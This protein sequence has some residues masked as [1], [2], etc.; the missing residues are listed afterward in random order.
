MVTHWSTRLVSTRAISNGYLQMQ[1]SQFWFTHSIQTSVK[2]ALFLC[3]I[4]RSRTKR[5]GET[6]VTESDFLWNFDQNIRRL[7]DES[8]KPGTSQHSAR[9]PLHTRGLKAKLPRMAEIS[10]DENAY[11][12]PV[13][14]LCLKRVTP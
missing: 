8:G 13:L 5:H 1:V 11:F 3:Q 9:F 2:K 6:V 10:R 7:L 12:P 4:L 14:F